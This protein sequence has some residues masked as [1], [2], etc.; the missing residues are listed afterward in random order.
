MKL[1]ILALIVAQVVFATAQVTPKP[2]P[3]DDGGDWAKKIK[4]LI[5]KFADKIAALIKSLYGAAGDSLGYLA[6]AA[7]VFWW[8]G[9]PYLTIIL[10]CGPFYDVSRASSGAPLYAGAVLLRKRNPAASRLL[11]AL[12]GVAYA[13][14]W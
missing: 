11:V 6:G 3:S 7:A 14:K 10:G 4:D 9:D 8:T 5:E 2:T 1:F 12:A 13:L